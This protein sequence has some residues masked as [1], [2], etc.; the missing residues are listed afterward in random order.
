MTA[1]RDGA[2]GQAGVDR[3]AMI[4]GGVG[5]LTGALLAQAVTAQGAS[6]TAIEAVSPNV[7]LLAEAEQG[8]GVWGVSESGEGVI[9]QSFFAAGV[10]GISSHGFGVVGDGQLLAGVVGN[11]RFASGVVGGN[12]ARDKPAV[13][14]WAQNGSTGVQGF[15]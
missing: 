14:G 7:A 15:S 3:R 4:A 10:H 5:V 12:V 6:S 2:G 13:Q 8:T 11:S 1:R 9:G